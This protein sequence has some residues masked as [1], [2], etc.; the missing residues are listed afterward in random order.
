MS[1][2]DTATSSQLANVSGGDE[3]LICKLWFQAV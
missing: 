3:V 2:F 1:G